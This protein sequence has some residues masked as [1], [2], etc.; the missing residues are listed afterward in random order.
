[1]SQTLKNP[2]LRGAFLP[3]L[4]NQNKHRRPFSGL[5]YGLKFFLLGVGFVELVEN[6]GDGL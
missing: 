1:M 2:D 3:E 4:V 6:V 5:H